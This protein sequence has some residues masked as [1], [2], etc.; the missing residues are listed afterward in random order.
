M[1]IQ[2]KS[3][4]KKAEI[5]VIGREIVLR[6]IIESRYDQESRIPLQEIAWA[7]CRALGRTEHI[8]KRLLHFLGLGD[9]TG[10]VFMIVLFF[11]WL[12]GKSIPLPVFLLLGLGPLVGGAALGMLLGLTTTRANEVRLSTISGNLVTIYVKKEQM[13]KL[14]ALLAN[15]GIQWK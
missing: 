10:T 3:Y 8:K 7:S 5:G 15:V 2:S 1:I 12:H 6:T 11:Q 9:G 13:R 14:R 4:F